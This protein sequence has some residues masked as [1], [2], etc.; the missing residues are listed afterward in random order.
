MI[1]ILA[2]FCQIVLSKANTGERIVI[3]VTD[4]NQVT[5]ETIP[6]TIGHEFSGTVLEVGTGVTAFK[7]GQNVSIQ[8]STTEPAVPANE[9]CKT[10]AIMEA[11][12]DCQVGVVDFQTHVW[13]QKTTSCHYQTTSLSMSQH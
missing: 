5:K 6:V 13:C 2:Q 9:I 11:L 4:N 8:Q 10:S 3:S 1:P 7:P 12:L